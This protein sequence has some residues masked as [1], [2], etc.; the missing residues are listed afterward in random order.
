M[1]KEQR[2]AK[3]KFKFNYKKTQPVINANV[4]CSQNF[5]VND[6]MIEVS[7]DDS[8]DLSQ[9]LIQWTG[10]HLSKKHRFFE[11]KFLSDI[12]KEQ[13]VMIGTNPR[14][15]AKPMV[16]DKDRC[17][18]YCSTEGGIFT[19][20]G[21]LRS[22]HPFGNE[23]DVIT[24]YLE[25]I[26]PKSSLINFFLNGRLVYRQWLDVAHTCLY[27]TIGVSKG[28]ACF[29]VTWP[30]HSKEPQLTLG[31]GKVHTLL[32]HW[33]GYRN[34]TQEDDTQIL[35]VTEHDQITRRGYSLQA[36]R[37]LTNAL[38]Y[39]EVELLTRVD[40]NYG[41]AIGLTSAWTSKF[42]YPGWKHDTI[43][44]H[45]DKGIVCNDGDESSDEPN[46][47]YQCQI[48]DRIGCGIVFNDKDHTKRQLVT[49]YFTKNGEIIH[50]KPRMLPMGGFYPTVGLYPIGDKVKVINPCTENKVL[51]PKE[52]ISKMKKSWMRLYNN[53]KFHET[54][55]FDDYLS[56]GTTRRLSINHETETAQMVHH[57]SGV[58]DFYMLKFEVIELGDN[59]EI[60]VRSVP[61][62]YLTSHRYIY[63]D[64]TLK[65]ILCFSKK[66]G[67]SVGDK[68]L[69]IIHVNATGLQITTTKNGDA[70][71]QTFAGKDRTPNWEDQMPTLAFQNGQAVVDVVWS[72]DTE[73]QAVQNNR[74]S[75]DLYIKE[76]MS[77]STNTEDTESIK[78]DISIEDLCSPNEN[79]QN[80]AQS[81]KNDEDS[82]TSNDARTASVHGSTST[83]P[84][85]SED[86]KSLETNETNK[87][88]EN[89]SKLERCAT[90]DGNSENIQNEEVQKNNATGTGDV[91]ET[92]TDTVKNDD[93]NSNCGNPQLARKRLATL[94]NRRSI[95]T[96]TNANKTEAN[97]KNGIKTP[98]QYNRVR[99]NST[100]GV[101]LINGVAVSSL[102]IERNK[103]I[104]DLEKMQNVKEPKTG[105]AQE[106][107]ETKKSEMNVDTIEHNKET[108]RDL[109]HAQNGKVQRK[110]TL[111]TGGTND[112]NMKTIKLQSKNISTQESEKTQKET[113]RKRSVTRINCNTNKT[114]INATN[115]EPNSKPSVNL[116]STQN[117]KVHKKIGTSL[118]IKNEYDRKTSSDMNLPQ[119]DKVR[120]NAT[121]DAR[122]TND[123]GQK[124]TKTEIK[125]SA[126]VQT[127]Q[128]KAQKRLGTLTNHDTNK[129]ETNAT[130]TGPNVTVNSY[131]KRAQNGRIQKKA[132]AD[133]S[134]TNGIGV[135]AM[136][137]ESKTTSNG[138]AK[139]MLVGKVRKNGSL[140]T[141]KTNEIEINSGT[142]KCDGYGNSIQATTDKAGT[143]AKSETTNKHKLENKNGAKKGHITYLFVNE[144]LKRVPHDKLLDTPETPVAYD[145]VMGPI[146]NER[147][148]KK[149][150]EI[151]K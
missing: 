39:F 30:G 148:R 142:N 70:L 23:G 89:P 81:E 136:A 28:P 120:K 129:I 29:K 141:P 65:D 131:L 140:G 50:V 96:E 125:T 137:T 97:S 138:D 95:K 91:V 130:K 68:V 76:Y 12:T 99:K 16:W 104:D 118:T 128:E 122:C 93:N 101:R 10:K 58:R 116:L 126:D 117:D 43:G 35:E 52:E 132:T 103:T 64:I 1:K 90:N 37:P 134:F 20:H 113:V 150:G 26:F 36:P 119:N 112:F 7:D 14:S 2:Y 110:A 143:I 145:I 87:I 51:L 13:L 45:S 149:N 98:A 46:E 139:Q 82:C 40:L 38:N 63:N 57:I 107:S 111:D 49:V 47:D 25:G 4:K 88:G 86:E 147:K 61:R 133:T 11:V 8:F 41:P 18:R 135:T 144:Y 59:T 53:F 48:G 54:I 73:F 71:R 24:V 5:H 27:P 9:S 121:S 17:I 62:C 22:G 123:S 75:I 69:V 21:G 114:E 102:R 77:P 80:D 15:N 74:A 19:S 146:G 78:S 42:Q 79:D 115:T 105:D 127:Q 31:I 83:L 94:K 92:E 32:S 3:D 44:Y 67:L 6:G 72:G 109:K 60:Y 151:I 100:P 56:C 85:Q 124:T 66:T 108:S 106:N 34:I 84:E 33:I 55:S